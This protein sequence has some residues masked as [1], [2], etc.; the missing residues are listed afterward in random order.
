MIGRTGMAAPLISIITPSFNRAAMIADAIESVLAQRDP[1]FEHITIDGGS[2]DGTL[3]VLKKYPHLRVV[4]EPDRGMY[5]ALNKGI[6]MAKG[7]I[8]GW[9]N[10]DDLYTEGAFAIVRDSFAN[11][12]ETL[13][14]SGAAENFFDNDSGRHVTH[15]DPP[16][17]DVDFWQR[18]VETPVPNGWFFRPEIFNRVGFFNVHYRYVADRDFFI[19]AALM[20]IHPATL[21]RVLYRYRQHAGSFTF[22]REDSRL[23]SAG[24]QRI[25]L[26]R[27]DVDMLETFLV[28]RDISNALR[29]A[30]II[31]HGMKSYQL[32]ATA[33]YHRDFR[34]A[35]NSSVHALRQNPFWLFEFIRRGSHRVLKEF[36]WVRNA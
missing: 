6:R 25:K 32:S 16:V 22:S 29:R 2:T 13:A 9:V 21:N 12:P 20:D 34:L 28:R 8:I 3:E 19:R 36:G 18:M 5:D 11:H 15:T 10:T 7:Q 4:S 17:S 1:A 14:V 24:Q 26:L 23:I 33:L 30:L 35:A 31:C 27:E